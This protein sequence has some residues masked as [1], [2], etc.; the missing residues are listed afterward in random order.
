MSSLA[1]MPGAVSSAMHTDDFQAL[2]Q[3]VL[4]AVELIRQERE[5]RAAAEA[6][7]ADLRRQL[8]LQT[9]SAEGRTAELESELA[10]YR[11]ERET[12]RTRVEKLLGQLDALA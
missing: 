10:Q 8:E 9:E 1:S 7:V 4:R 12:V 5:A 3:R 6:E 2:E 11:Q